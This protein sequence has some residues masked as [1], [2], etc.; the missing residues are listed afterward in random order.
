MSNE[1]IEI[2]KWEDDGQ[3]IFTVWKK[4]G[5]AGDAFSMEVGRQIAC[6]PF[7]KEISDKDLHGFIKGLVIGVM[8]I[9]AVLYGV[10]MFKSDGAIDE[11]VSVYVQMMKED[12]GDGR[13]N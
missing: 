2:R 8:A 9:T 3:T 12:S 4:G 7:P 5:S 6:Y 13:L 10:Q 11:F 1:E